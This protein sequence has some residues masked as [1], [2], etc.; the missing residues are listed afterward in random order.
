MLES[1]RILAAETVPRELLLLLEE[2]VDAGIPLAVAKEALELVR[3]RGAD[4]LCPASERL[5]AFEDLD[6]ALLAS[7]EALVLRA[8]L[9][10]RDRV[11]EPVR[12][13]REPDGHDA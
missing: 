6:E 4:G 1:E 13:S 11:L 2:F 8:E 5:A 7:V 3:K 10:T 9:A 12:R